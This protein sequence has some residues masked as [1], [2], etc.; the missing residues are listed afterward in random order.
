MDRI[1]LHSD[2]NNFYASV[3]CF[4][5]PK[6]RGLPVA[7]TGD[8]EKRHGI[9]LAKNGIAKAHGI[10]TGEPLWKAKKKCG[11]LVCIS[12]HFERYTKFSNMA[13]K[14]YAE[15]TDLVESFGPDECWLDITKKGKDINYGK[16]VAEIIRQRIKDELGITVSIG[17]SF[18]KVFA[19]LGSD[20]KKPDAVTVISRENYKSIV[21]PMSVDNLLFVGRATLNKLK[22]RGCSTI[23]DLGAMSRES[24]EK[25]LGKNGLTIHDFAN[26]NEHSPVL[27]LYEKYPIKSIGNSTTAFRDLTTDDDIKIILMTLAES[28]SERLR[29]AKAKC[30]LVQVHFRDTKLHSFERQQIIE[31]TDISSEIFNAAFKLYKANN[32]GEALRSIGI[33]ASSLL[34]EETTQQSLI[35]TNHEKLEKLEN[36]IDNIRERFGHFSVG[37]ALMLSDTELSAFDPIADHTLHFEP[38]R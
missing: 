8:P 14:I 18:N 26:G 34:F 16:E 1:I 35:E 37:R 10:Q 12:S 5:D 20:Y 19:K 21:W 38:Y 2:L 15:Y 7:V 30:N 6:F 4:N 36:S 27:P 9:I 31:P 29:D 32:K 3:E 22:T 11:N 28:V 33:K 17:V 13:K 24:L 23:G 25:L